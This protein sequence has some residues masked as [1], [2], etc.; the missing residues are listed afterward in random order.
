MSPGP[1]A[2]SAATLEIALVCT[3]REE[4]AAPLSLA[5]I[6]RAAHRDDSLMPHQARR[7]VPRGMPQGRG[8]SPR[9]YDFSRNGTLRRQASLGV[10]IEG[11]KPIEIERNRQPF[12]HEGHAQRAELADDRIGSHPPVDDDFVPQRLDILDFED[13]R[14]PIARRDRLGGMD[15][16]GTDADDDFPSAAS[17]ERRANGLRQRQKKGFGHDRLR[18]LLHP[19]GEEIHRRRSDELSD[20]EVGGFAI[21]LERRADLTVM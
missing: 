15:V 13:R 3:G 20:E 1:E 19:A 16:L 12:A 11:M 9:Q 5:A 6:S 4:Q 7:V 18:P 17:G 14:G 8:G 21:D 2:F 10:R